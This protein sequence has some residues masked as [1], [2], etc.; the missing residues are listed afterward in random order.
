MMFSMWPKTNTL[1]ITF[2]VGICLWAP[3]ASHWISLFSLEFP[4]CLSWVEQPYWGQLCCYHSHCNVQ[5]APCAKPNQ[6]TRWSSLTKYLLLL[7]AAGQ[8]DSSVGQGCFSLLSHWPD[9]LLCYLGDANIEQEVS[10]CKRL[11]TSVLSVVNWMEM[12]WGM[13]KTGSHEPEVCWFLFSTISRYVSYTS[14]TRTLSIDPLIDY[15]DHI[16]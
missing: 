9:H 12:K 2:K 8:E 16:I 3:A 4:M 13:R 11:S 6:L 14:L 5:N 7:E 1:L 15:S 10:K